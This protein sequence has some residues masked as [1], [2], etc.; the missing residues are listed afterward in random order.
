M[1]SLLLGFAPSKLI[2]LITMISK[3]LIAL[4]SI[5][6]VLSAEVIL[7]PQSILASPNIIPQNDVLVTRYTVQFKNYLSSIN[8]VISSPDEFKYRLNLYVA[9]TQEIDA[10]NK[11]NL[12]YK[13][14]LNFFSVLT[15]E[16]RFKFLGDRESD[17]K[18]APT[19]DR[20]DTTDGNASGDS[21]L[22]NNTV[23]AN[24]NNLFFKWPFPINFFNFVI[25]QSKDW[26]AEGKIT[27]VKNQGN[28]GSCWAFAAVAV[29]EAAYKIK[30]NINLDLAE[31]ELVDCSQQLGSDG[32]NGGFSQGALEYF[33]AFG[34]RPEGSYPY[35]AKN[36][37]CKARLPI[38]QKIV[39]YTGVAPGNMLNYINNLKLRPMTTSFYV[40]NSFFDY[41]SGVFNAS[42]ECSDLGSKGTNHAVLAVG[43]NLSAKT[44]FIKL[45]NSWGTGW[46]ESGFFRIS[47]KKVISQDGPCNLIKR[48]RT[49]FPKL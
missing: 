39:S 34:V 22:P 48:D 36:G 28:C 25:P 24:T 42:T 3:I 37:S 1:G 27:P 5:T 30:N 16:E 4:L 46:G 31:Q 21:A 45:K 41:K 14:G 19:V 18:N 44:P 15:I 11:L 49:F 32:C 10:F 33:K 9:K 20:A 29:V 7:T 8:Q 6:A 26:A 23:A 47:M 12:D 35:T 2:N 40:V 13:K 38:Q 43:Y 17:P